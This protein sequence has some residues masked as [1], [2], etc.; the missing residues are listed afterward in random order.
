MECQKQFE[1][2]KIGC[3]A[4]SS[5]F[6]QQLMD[7]NLHGAS[8]TVFKNYEL[9][10]I[11]V[12]IE[13]VDNGEQIWFEKCTLMDPERDLDCLEQMVLKVVSFTQHL[14]KQNKKKV[15]KAD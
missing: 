4:I 3:D 8:M 6:H 9:F 15:E 13:V 5:R 14:R 2:L 7:D 10:N 12:V 1:A 11:G